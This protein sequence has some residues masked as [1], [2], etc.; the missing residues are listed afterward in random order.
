MGWESTS[1]Q[2]IR[3]LLVAGGLCVAAVLG[4]KVLVLVAEPHMAFMP[5]SGDAAA[6]S[7]F[8]L[9]AEPFETVTVDGMRLRGW[10]IPARA[11][12]G[13][14]APRMGAVASRAPLTILFFHGNAENISHCLE[15]GMLTRSAGYNLALVDYRGYGGNRG[16][17]SETGLYRD[18]EAALRA[19]RGLRGVDP[20]R[21]VVWGRS[22]G[23][24]VAVHLA[25][26]TPAGAAPTATGDQAGPPAG[27]ILES[28][29][30]S[31][32]DLLREGGHPLL[33][34]LSRLGTFRFDSAAAIRRVRSPLLIIHGTADEIAPFALGQR[35][36][37][38]A[39]GR[40]ELAAIAGGGHND[41]MALHAAE[42]WAA[43]D[44]FL[45]SLD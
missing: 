17:P 23:A 13:A 37:G 18:G 42:L 29:F 32:Q 39:P 31:V 3:T 20:A 30:T 35:L 4:L 25:A 36:Y 33:L 27:V 2:V 34:A 10:L 5:P 6:P 26:A 44:R 16:Q 40:R 22:I 28:P 15:L 24:A 43:A 12:G 14:G 41:L 45:K 19:V 38:L 11:P 7:D 1:F 8:A 9:P 21:V